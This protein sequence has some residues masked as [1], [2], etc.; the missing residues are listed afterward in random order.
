[1]RQVD[2]LREI[3]RLRARLEREG[4]PR[5]QMAVIVAITAGS[6]F[7]A[8][9]YLLRAGVSE[10]W[11]RYP[12]AF[13]IAYLV[14]LGSLWLWMRSRARDYAEVADLLPADG[15]GAGARSGSGYGGR[16][17]ASGGGGASSSYDEPAASEAPDAEGGSSLGG[18]VD[19]AAEGASTADDLAVPVVA[20]VAIA[21]LGVSLLS[22]FWIIISAPTFFAELLVDGVLATTLY[23]VL[24]ADESR[25]W[26]R[27]AVRRTLLPVLVATTVA[28]LA[29]WLMALYAPAARSIGD[30]LL[31]AK[32]VR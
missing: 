2:R 31:H 12:A 23:R 15:P 3:H 28:A 29:G 4:S 9:Y 16:G 5:L 8:T 30:V 1:M 22:S 20:V 21:L 27:T 19:A 13:A 11:L 14:F 6:G 7:L 25:H 24:R 10:M 17:G 26:L 32:G 18:A